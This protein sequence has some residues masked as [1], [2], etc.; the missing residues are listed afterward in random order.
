MTV[1]KLIV[2]LICDD[3]DIF[4]NGEHLLRDYQIIDHGK[5]K[6]R[7][8]ALENEKLYICTDECESDDTVYYMFESCLSATHCLINKEYGLNRATLI[9]LDDVLFINVHDNILEV[10]T[11]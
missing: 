8:W 9:E 1:E 2:I 7:A 6:V 5:E 4:V 11:R 3:I 10:M